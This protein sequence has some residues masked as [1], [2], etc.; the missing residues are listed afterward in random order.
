MKTVKLGEIVDIKGGGTP[1]KSVPE[2]WRGDIP[3]ASVKDFK[4]TEIISTADSITQ[5]GVK[6]SATNIIPSGAIIVP[7][8]MAVGKAAINLIDIAINQDLKALFPKPNIDTHYLLHALLVNSS[9]LE[10]Q[11][12][13]ATVK[14]ITL[15]V[16]RALEIPLPLLAEQKRIAAILDQADTLRRLRQRSL[17][18]LDQLGQAI[19]YE[20]FGDPVTNPKGWSRIPFSKLLENI[21]SGWSPICLD[22]AAAESEWGVLKLGAVTWCEYNQL[23]NKALPPNIQADPTL[24]VCNGDL[25]FTRKNTYGLVAACVHVKSTR[26]KLMISDLIFRFRLRSISEVEPCFLHQLLIYPSKR[27]QIQKL[28]SGSA[29]SMPNI[30]KGKLQDVLIEIP[31]FSLQQEFASRVQRIETIKEP[32][33]RSLA[34]YDALFSSLQHRA[35]RGEL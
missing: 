26:P 32:C 24:E 27:Q 25:L 31:P 20:M 10:R 5:L 19:F 22:R 29:S 21:D 3:W 15:E 4:S 11:A 14:G 35:F 9:K 16:L 18:R 33:S 12:T 23:E 17:D 7:T 8:R 28:A 13:G 30:S 1:D 6:N 34:E 2:Y